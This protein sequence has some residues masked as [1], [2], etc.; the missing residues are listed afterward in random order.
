MRAPDRRGTPA[1]AAEDDALPAAQKVRV[2]VGSA[3]GSV[4]SSYVIMVAVAGL[5]GATASAPLEPL[6]LLVAGLPLWLS[7][8]QVPLIIAGAPLSALPLLPTVGI[9]MVTAG[10]AAA[11][12][13]RLGGRWDADA[14]RVVGTL[15]V[16][17]ASLA[18]LTTA[19]PTDP[20][21]AEPWPALL[22]AGLV[23][24]AGAAL[25]VLR[26]AGVPNRWSLAPRW[27]R[28]GLT[29]AATGLAAL[30]TVAALLVLVGLT[31]D[32][33]T[34]R[35]GFD[36]RPGFGAELGVAV[37]S[38]CYLPNAVVSA[39]SW[40]AGPGLIVGSA[41]ASPLGVTVGPLP[42]LPLLAVMPTSPPPGWVAAVFVL[43]V[44]AGGMIG[45]RCRRTGVDPMARLRAVGAA[46]TTVALV[47]LL[48]ATLVSGRL[49]AGPFDPVDLPALSGALALFGW[50]VVPASIVALVPAALVPAGLVRRKP[51]RSAQLPDL[52]GVRRTRRVEASQQAREGGA[53]VEH[54]SGAPTS[55]AGTD[56]SEMYETK[57]G[58]TGVPDG[59][60]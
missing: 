39:V 16:A 3:L 40:L 2:L 28:V 55:G 1:R 56:R 38:I 54:P 9:A 24:A 11:A 57:P 6:A 4:L 30:A 23:S 12:L 52:P 46:V 14:G 47:F 18:V 34:V 5:A 49:A 35:V 7:A 53:A 15:A 29:A 59:D 51:R 31:V 33:R 36:M 25:G 37:L 50:L 13:G 43:P 60:Q 22:G 44:L 17:H 8:H 20:V 42:P 21:R 32:V 26:V 48:A 27:F 41:A 45:L 58:G 19:L 10:F